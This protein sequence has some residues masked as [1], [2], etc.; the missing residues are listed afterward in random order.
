MNIDRR[1]KKYE[2]AL[3]AIAGSFE[4]VKE[5]AD[6][7]FFLQKLSL[8]IRK[9]DYQKLPYDRKIFKRLGQCL[10]FGLP[11]GIHQ[12]ALSVVSTIFEKISIEE[13]NRNVCIYSMPIFSFYPFGSI[14]IRK[15][16]LALFGTFYVRHGINI[17]SCL[18]NL[19]TCLLTGLENE[20]ADFTASVFV[21]LQNISREVPA[22]DFYHAVWVSLLTSSDERL[23]VCKYLF[24]ALQVQDLSIIAHYP[25]AVSIALIAGLTDKNP[26]VVR[27]TLD[28][29]LGGFP[30]KTGL[31]TREQMLEVFYAVLLVFLHKDASL[32]RRAADWLTASGIEESAALTAEAFHTAYE[33]R[34][35]DE[36]LFRILVHLLDIK[37][38]G[39]LLC[40]KMFRFLVLICLQHSKE[41]SVCSEEDRSRGSGFIKT[42]NYFFRALEKEAVWPHI[43]ALG[44]ELGT[45]DM[46][47]ALLL[48]SIS[49][50]DIWDEM[51]PE[52]YDALFLLVVEHIAEVI[53]D[54]TREENIICCQK[55]ITLILRR[56]KWHDKGNVGIEN[57]DNSMVHGQ[58]RHALQAAA[59]KPLRTL[60]RDP[61]TANQKHIGF[62]CEILF[63]HF[64]PSHDE[65][66][67]I[68]NDLCHALVFSN[69]E[70]SIELLYNVFG[71]FSR[72]RHLLVHKRAVVERLANAI[73]D[74]SKK[75]L[76]LFVLLH[77]RES[78]SET[79]L[80]LLSTQYKER[81]RNA[82]RF[83]SMLI[84]STAE[85][86]AFSLLY[87]L[88]V[89]LSQLALPADD[90]V[91]DVCE[92]LHEAEDSTPFYDTVCFFLFP[93]ETCFSK[94]TFKTNAGIKV[95]LDKCTTA[96][97][98][99]K[100]Y[101]GFNLLFLVLQNT[102]T[103]SLSQVVTCKRVSGLFQKNIHNT[104]DVRLNYAEMFFFAAAK[105]LL[106]FRSE[107][108]FGETQ[109]IL[110]FLMLEQN[111][112]LISTHT[113]SFVHS[114][115]MDSLLVF[116]ENI[117]RLTPL[118]QRMLKHIPVLSAQKFSKLSAACL[119][120]I[121]E[122]TH[123]QCWPGIFDVLLQTQ[124]GET[125]S[126]TLQLMGSS[127]KEIVL[128]INKQKKFVERLIRL[129][130]DGQELLDYF[131]RTC[132][133]SEI[134]FLFRSALGSIRPFTDAAQL[135]TLLELGMVSRP[136]FF[137]ALLE[138]F[139]SDK[140]AVAA[141]LSK[142]DFGDEIHSFFLGRIEEKIV[143]KEDASTEF[144]FFLLL[145]EKSPPKR[146][147]E[148]W[149]LL[150]QMLL[151]RQAEIGYYDILL[152]T[153]YIA[154]AKDIDSSFALTFKQCI[155]ALTSTKT[156]VRYALMLPED[157]VEMFSLLSIACP[158][159]FAEAGA[160]QSCFFFAK[161]V[162][163][164]L[165]RM[166]NI[167]AA[168]ILQ[169]TLINTV[170]PLL[171]CSHPLANFAFRIFH[172]IAGAPNAP[173]S[174]KKEFWD[175]FIEPSF[176]SATTHD[177]FASKRGLAGL[178][179]PYER[180]DDLFEKTQNNILFASEPIKSR[181]LHIRRMSFLLLAE[182]HHHEEYFPQ[183]QTK[184]SELLKTPVS[185]L[186]AE[187]YLLL[188]I[189]L[190]KKYE[191]LLLKLEPIIT[192]SL[193]ELFENLDD[194]P[195]KLSS[196]L[197]AAKFVYVLLASPL[198]STQIHR[199]TIANP[200]DETNTT[201]FGL[202]E[203]TVAETG[204]EDPISNLLYKKTIL[205]TCEI[206]PF[207]LQAKNLLQ[208]DALAV[209]DTAAMVASIEEDLLSL[210]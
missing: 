13:F 198:P 77:L 4:N 126:K 64:R 93:A 8:T 89:F 48:H 183:I 55:I 49:H 1:Y 181:K 141:L 47:A 109:K 156:K 12:K 9:Y 155:E 168:I 139:S 149:N 200:H 192:S 82:F 157:Y 127:L 130:E 111:R 179:F 28:I 124:T 84:P 107:C 41:M 208:D 33:M 119:L 147:I 67:S 16:L 137:S 73:I 5:W 85:L 32:S 188:R 171:T 123:M 45:A 197:M 128:P 202:I 65:L 110:F 174:W 169:N 114:R 160:P 159:P 90:A 185:P 101:Y 125:K 95:R 70:E 189:L 30:Q 191:N 186:H 135:K 145:L 21:L 17:S 120:S 61:P 154:W 25:R 136:L 52:D 115:L 43:V 102:R 58:I 131:S 166:P 11:A 106:L 118:L 59:K 26:L 162:F 75:A 164:S 62:L 50:L 44:R 178:L 104:G 46:A 100:I 194:D 60:R 132:L 31:F 203:K 29:L 63:L 2:E 20:D 97:S 3:D 150:A 175:V 39:I 205:S 201:L 112:C 24:G 158:A 122:K 103:S 42:A 66:D 209:S 91:L 204:K 38:M 140:D 19:V 146:S 113:L 94:H 83:F 92:T 23:S 165:Q 187:V 76:M 72:S 152:C 206:H 80:W 51:I 54:E 10:Q 56:K 37:E 81:R 35:E 176:F 129:I 144:R 105:N 121:R 151:I 116:P 170:L 14:A 69:C 196:L 57:K 96:F 193:F 40:N 74:G 153:K 34:Q 18:Q 99:E 88:T 172:L 78:L 86:P 184:I 79:L 7:S 71:W 195:Q 98:E 173:K 210:E 133:N 22:V 53:L 134:V 108:I 36:Q 163:P 142:T 177:A 180:I 148:E 15:Q 207:I 68:W 87:P 190:L 6:F 167:N 138:L 199:W 182:S 117:K 161:V 27:E 143:R